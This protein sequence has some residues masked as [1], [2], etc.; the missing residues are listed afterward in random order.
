MRDK[1]PPGLLDIGLKV[2]V[3]R[4]SLHV[5]VHALLQTAYQGTHRGPSWDRKWLAGDGSLVHMRVSI[6]I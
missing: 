2:F 5:E 6:Y 1:G 4:H 3:P